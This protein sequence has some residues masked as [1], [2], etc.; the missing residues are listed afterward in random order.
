MPRSNKPITEVLIDHEEKQSLDTF[1]TTLETIAK[2]LKSEGHFDFVQGT[3]SI[4]VT[5]SETIKVEYEY[6]KK[7][8]KHSFEIEFDWYEGEKAHKSMSIK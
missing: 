1:A 8:D 4:T 7:A 2:K 3:E 5:P 6:T